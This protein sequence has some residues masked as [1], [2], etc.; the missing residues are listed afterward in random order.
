MHHG[1]SES[2]GVGDITIGIIQVII[3]IIPIIIGEDIIRITTTPIMDMR[4]II[5]TTMAVTMIVWLIIGDIEIMADTVVRTMIEMRHE[6]ERI[7]PAQEI[8]IVQMI[9]LAPEIM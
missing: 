6:T 9:I 7:I 3:L 2:V 8:I 4:I 1:A 5:P